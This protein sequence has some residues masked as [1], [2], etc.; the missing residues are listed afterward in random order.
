MVLDRLWL[1]YG[2]L[3]MRWVIIVNMTNGEKDR[4]WVY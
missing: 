3:E 4:G 1:N 2:D